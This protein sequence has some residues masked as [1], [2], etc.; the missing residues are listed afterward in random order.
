M[1]P[2]PY[3]VDHGYRDK[4]ARR[5]LFPAPGG[6]PITLT[7][8]VRLLEL[9]VR[10][11]FC[12]AFLDRSPASRLNFRSEPEGWGWRTAC[13]PASEPVPRPTRFAAYRRRPSWRPRTRHWG[14]PKLD[15]KPS[16]KK[17]RDYRR[18]LSVMATIF[19]G[20]GGRIR[21][22]DLRVMSPTSCHCSTPRRGNTFFN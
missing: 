12:W 19:I 4:L 10:W 7:R 15:Q 20:S 2:K 1:L 3:L 11:R 18:G 21:T 17:P 5:Q 9:V 22:Y 6:G 13:P 14:Q 16:D 8:P